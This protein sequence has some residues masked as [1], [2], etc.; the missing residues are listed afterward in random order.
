MQKAKKP[1]RSAD[2]PSSMGKV[3]FHEEV[4]V[5]KIKAKGKNLPVSTMYYEEE[6]EDDDYDDDDEY[7]DEE[8]VSS[9]EDEDEDEGEEMYDE[10]FRDS[11]SG[12]EDV[13]MGDDEEEDSGLATMERLRDDLFADDDDGDVQE[14]TLTSKLR[15]ASSYTLPRAIYV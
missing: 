9:E 10:E 1:T 3:R 8:G 6:E 7:E 4:K 13:S 15:Y 14:G 2:E 12:E 5:R 11:H